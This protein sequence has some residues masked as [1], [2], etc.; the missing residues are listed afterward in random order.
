MGVQ[1]TLW[2][3]RRTTTIWP[4]AHAILAGVG[5]APPVAERPHAVFIALGPRH[6]QRMSTLPPMSIVSTRSMQ[7]IVST[8]RDRT[9][10]LQAREAS[11]GSVEMRRVFEEAI[12]VCRDGFCDSDASGLLPVRLLVCYAFSIGGAT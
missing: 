2:R 10:T 5:H 3:A 4:Q 6:N 9:T 12:D 11:E 7:S 1:T 8:D